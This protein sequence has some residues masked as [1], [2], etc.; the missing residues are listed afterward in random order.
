M[1]WQLIVL[2]SHCF[3]TCVV[4]LSNL[5]AYRDLCAPL[6]VTSLLIP[7]LSSYG[8]L[9]I[10]QCLLNHGCQMDVQTDG[11]STPLHLASE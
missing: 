2:S 5:S 6:P 1:L 4:L 8:H 9:E 10:V 3:L 7:T 11:G